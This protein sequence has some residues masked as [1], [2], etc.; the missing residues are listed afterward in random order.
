MKRSLAEP[1]LVEQDGVSE[2]HEENIE[3]LGEVGLVDSQT[4]ACIERGGV[5]G[6]VLLPAVPELHVSN[7]LILMSYRCWRRMP[8]P[9]DHILL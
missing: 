9:C 4:G 6:N 2:C 3:R 8:G 7:T 1:V 5:E